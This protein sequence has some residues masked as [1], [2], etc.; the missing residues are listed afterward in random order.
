MITFACCLRNLTLWQ[1]KHVK[2]ID[3]SLPRN[4]LN[5]RL[6]SKLNINEKLE[7]LNRFPYANSNIFLS[8]E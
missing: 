3:N 5:L 7:L 4:I 2:F 8:K 1:A 6:N